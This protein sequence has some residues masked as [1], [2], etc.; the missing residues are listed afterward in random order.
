MKHLM[1]NKSSKMDSKTTHSINNT[2]KP[3]KIKPKMDKNTKKQKK[4][5]TTPLK[6][7]KKV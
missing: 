2:I 4:T 6:S 5:I 7:T 3:L 1:T